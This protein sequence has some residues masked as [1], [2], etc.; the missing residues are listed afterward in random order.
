MRW[1]IYN[2]YFFGKNNFNNNDAIKE[3]TRAA[4]FDFVN[5]FLIKKKHIRN[6]FS[7]RHELDGKITNCK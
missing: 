3:L 6:L 4:I 7:M 1:S 5:K 2:D